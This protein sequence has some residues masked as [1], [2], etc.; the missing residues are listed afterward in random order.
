[1]VVPF[2]Q[3]FKRVKK[4]RK[5]RPLLFLLKLVKSMANKESKIAV[6][7]GTVTD[8]EKSHDVPRFT[9]D[10]P[11]LSTISQASRFRC[12][13]TSVQRQRT[14]ISW[15]KIHLD[16]VTVAPFGV[17]ETGGSFDLSRTRMRSTCSLACP[18]RFPS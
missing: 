18:T 14:R 11:V 12:S 1:M 4:I 16:G 13:R 8:D 9:V 3:A 6:V 10:L 2:H 15:V 5:N 17:R 7:A